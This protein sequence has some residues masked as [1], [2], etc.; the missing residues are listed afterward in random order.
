M[1]CFRG[2]LAGGAP[3]ALALPGTLRLLGGLGR[4]KPSA[5]TALAMAATGGEP[6]A[7]HGGRTAED[8]FFI[9]DRGWC[10]GQLTLQVYEALSLFKESLKSL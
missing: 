8:L 4:P 3:P 9:C 7:G 1:R 6:P 10:L 5:G 2:C